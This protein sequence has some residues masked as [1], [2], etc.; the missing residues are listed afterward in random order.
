M[1]N[2]LELAFRDANDG[3]S[4]DRV[5]ADPD[6]NARFISACRKHGLNE[7]P[8]LL[9]RKLINLRKSGQLRVRAER[10]IR[11]ADLEIQNGKS[12]RLVASLRRQDHLFCKRRQESLCTGL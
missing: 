11:K 5:L 7:S 12:R 3:Y 8:I 1:T 4:T 2:P 6:L 10:E 9:N